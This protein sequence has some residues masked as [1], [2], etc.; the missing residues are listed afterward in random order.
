MI[1]KKTPGGFAPRR[2]FIF[3]MIPVPKFAGLRRSLLQQVYQLL[4][5]V[6]PM[7]VLCET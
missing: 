1:H 5:R 2:F 7:P 3:T 4:G 6:Q